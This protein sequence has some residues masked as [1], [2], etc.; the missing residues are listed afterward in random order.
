M[1]SAYSRKIEDMTMTETGY[2]DG[3]HTLAIGNYFPL[4][5]P[6]ANTALNTVKKND[7]ANFNKIFIATHDYTQGDSY[8][9]FG[10][11]LTVLNRKIVIRAGDYVKA[12]MDFKDK[13]IRL[14]N[15]SRIE[16]KP[17]DMIGFK[18][19]GHQRIAYDVN[20]REEI[21]NEKIKIGSDCDCVVTVNVNAYIHTLGSVEVRIFVDEISDDP[22]FVTSK[23]TNW[24]LI[25]KEVPMDGGYHG[26]IAG[27]NAE[28]VIKNARKN[29]VYT[30]RCDVVNKVDHTINPDE[31]TTISETPTTDIHLY[32]D[33]VMFGS[34]SMTVT[35]YELE[36][37][38]VFQYYDD[39]IEANVYYKVND[40]D[41]VILL[42]TDEL[43][44]V[45]DVNK[46]DR[47][48]FSIPDEIDDMPVV[49]L[50]NGFL[51][52][53]KNRIKKLTIGENVRKIGNFVF[54]ANGMLF[55]P[56]D[57][58]CPNFYPVEIVANNRPE[59]GGVELGAFVFAW[60]II[61]GDLV[62]YPVEWGNVIPKGYNT[63]CYPDQF[64]YNYMSFGTNILP[65]GNVMYGGLQECN[66]SCDSASYDNE[67]SSSG[68]VQVTRKFRDDVISYC[69]EHAMSGAI[70]KIYSD[71]QYPFGRNV[72]EGFFTANDYLIIQDNNTDNLLRVTF[73][74][75]A[76]F[77]SICPIC[78]TDFNEDK[79]ERLYKT[80]S[81]DGDL[82][83]YISDYNFYDRCYCGFG[84]ATSA[85]ASTLSPTLSNLKLET[86]DRKNPNTGL[87]YYK[88]LYDTAKNIGILTFEPVERND[89]D[90]PTQPLNRVIIWNKAWHQCGRSVDREIP[91]YP[92]H[93][94][95]GEEKYKFDTDTTHTEYMRNLLTGNPL[96]KYAPIH[97]PAN[98]VF[99]VLN[100]FASDI[101]F[102]DD[103]ADI[104]NIV[105]VQKRLPSGYIHTRGGEFNPTFLM[106]SL[107]DAST[108][109][110][111]PMWLHGTRRDES[112]SSVD[113]PHNMLVLTDYLFAYG[114]AASASRYTGEL[115]D[116]PLS[117][118]VFYTNNFVGT[119][120]QTANTGVTGFMGLAKQLIL[121]NPG[122]TGLKWWHGHVTAAHVKVY[123]K[124]I[125]SYADSDGL[126]F[127]DPKFQYTPVPLD[128]PLT[129]EAY[130]NDP[131][132]PEG[133]TLSDQTK[134][135]N[136]WVFTEDQFLWADNSNY[137]SLTPSSS[138]YK[139][140]TGYNEVADHAS[141]YCIY[142][143]EL[144]TDNPHVVMCQVFSKLGQYHIHAVSRRIGNNFLCQPVREGTNNAFFDNCRIV[145]F[146]QGT[147][148]IQYHAVYKGCAG[149][150]QIPPSCRILENRAIEKRIYQQE[151]YGNYLAVPFGCT[152]EGT[153]QTCYGNKNSNYNILN[154]LPIFRYDIENDME[155]AYIMTKD[156]DTM[157]ATITKMN[158]DNYYLLHETSTNAKTCFL[159]SLGTL[160]M[161]KVT[162]SG[163]TI[164]AITNTTTVG[165]VYQ[166]AR[167]LSEFILPPDL[168]ITTITQYL[169]Y[170][171]RRL[172][173]TN[174][175]ATVTSIEKYAYAYT[176]HLYDFDIAAQN[177]T[178]VG[179]Y[180]FYRCGFV[181]LSEYP[182]SFSDKS[183][184]Q[185][186]VQN[187]QSVFNVMKNAFPPFRGAHSF[188]M[189]DGITYIG[190]Y[191]FSCTNV[192]QGAITLPRNESYT[193][194]KDYTFFMN[195]GVT[196]LT[197]P[198][199]IT[200]IGK[201][202]FSQMMALKKIVIPA[203]VT[204]FNTNLMLCDELLEADI[205]CAQPA[206]STYSDYFFAQCRSLRRVNIPNFTRVGTRMFNGCMSLFE[207]HL[208]NVTQIM[209]Y[210]FEG[211]NV[212]EIHIY[213][214]CTFEAYALQD[215]H[216]LRRIVCH[217]GAVCTF[218]AA[219]LIPYYLSGESQSRS[220]F[221]KMEPGTYRFEYGVS[222][223]GTTL[224]SG[225]PHNTI[226]IPG[227][228][229]DFVDKFLTDLAGN[230][231]AIPTTYT[232]ACNYGTPMF[233]NTCAVHAP[234]LKQREDVATYDHSFPSEID[235]V[236]YLHN[237]IPQTEGSLYTGLECVAWLN[238]GWRFYND[239]AHDTP[240]TTYN[241]V[242]NFILR[243]MPVA[244]QFSDSGFT[245]INIDYTQASSWGST[246]P[247]GRSAFAH[248]AVSRKYVT[249]MCNNCTAIGEQSFALHGMYYTDG[250][251]DEILDK[252]GDDI[253][254]VNLTINNAPPTTVGVSSFS[255]GA[256]AF[257]R[258][259]TLKTVRVDTTLASITVSQ[260]AFSWCPNLETVT[261]VKPVTFYATYTA[262]Q[263]QIF[264]Q[265]NNLRTV[266]FEGG[267][268]SAVTADIIK[269]V[270]NECSVQV[271]QVPTGTDSSLFAQL[272][273]D[274]TI[275]YI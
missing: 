258:I 145:T 74:K 214:D 67:N 41:E 254:I 76:R 190:N 20:N 12:N 216:N 236:G 5:Y 39:D 80:A 113:R 232:N 242:N 183:S 30:I 101:T 119:K 209:G 102:E 149:Y 107:F 219:S 89:L 141:G 105:G 210:A 250:E 72:R 56:A 127:D 181:L 150:I 9:M 63:F 173:K 154:T 138:S 189:H 60:R 134:H 14:V 270:F 115:P 118:R 172:C 204:T 140:S 143:P 45:S 261:F 225:Q 52:D 17:V 157:T 266:R 158:Y 235:S 58:K 3:V 171:L 69:N 199:T 237:Q 106:H 184:P 73:P 255:I 133:S 98:T 243:R 83:F 163:H 142:L 218:K 31:L 114:L 33:F 170:Y 228:D 29:D 246:Y 36:R 43:Q 48:D 273:E 111:A 153:T 197:V 38:G 132:S 213:Q 104:R 10:I 49:E 164:T 61:T 146:G 226:G 192:I 95:F 35:G 159:Y 59:S 144:L 91:D 13:T 1:A 79:A 2:S 93:D 44:Y 129:K 167:N 247:I 200:S 269:S 70:V 240:N 202:A 103:T 15:L 233:T 23:S 222:W 71:N 112:S 54:S 120:R 194:V 85:G 21:F 22:V 180:G 68:W 178:Y 274:I 224:F 259:S 37:S 260:L 203:S 121:K 263:Y 155:Q 244:Y 40:D 275:E 64:M 100:V 212:R 90:D 55:P 267:F 123:P 169:C 253:H 176:D 116:T 99:E 195:G 198:D 205:L 57:T 82:P 65:N 139:L 262:M 34:T 182:E 77:L 174:I 66:Q 126:V 229:G 272:P 186:G 161:P 168:P 131:L 8:S 148:I 238:G 230:E 125:K 239:V 249:E 32:D 50:A 268:L 179:D 234:I 252:D 215:A 4:R 136:Q 28:Y 62:E 187:Y 265:C 165:L 27:I 207:I 7:D 96:Y 19:W 6:T 94:E 162:A 221:E 217:D 109:E 92:L 193:A 84:M 135:K 166:F 18:Y 208:P 175:P 16:F 124:T 206:S 177:I 11:N 156:D 75:T 188:R 122:E 117:E 241:R 26:S 25:A 271:I 108:Y 196:E 264:K 24:A 53:S 223:S 86:L 160:L 191:A 42:S 88:P 251:L 201:Y 137:N 47:V 227:V 81:R 51:A 97:I 151:S 256:A 78:N 185:I 220:L 46:D 128:T 257:A 147:E 110:Y 231:K 245:D 152:V 211:C 130:L 248:S 87:R